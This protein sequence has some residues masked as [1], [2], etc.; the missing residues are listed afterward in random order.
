LEN[1]WETLAAAKQLDDVAFI[2][3]L[4]DL[5]YVQRQYGFTKESFAT[6]GPI[7]PQVRSY[8]AE[9]PG[10][11]VELQSAYLDLV[12]EYAS[13]LALRDGEAAGQELRDQVK[14]QRRKL[15][16]PGSEL[17]RVGDDVLPPRPSRRP[18]PTFTPGAS[19]AGVE[20][21]VVVSVEIWEDGR[22]HNMKVYRH[23]PFGLT[24]SG[25]RALRKWRFEPGTKEGKPVK[26]SATIEM[27]FRRMRR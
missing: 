8:L 15:I 23:F 9:K 21:T 4:S 7:V 11:P 27:N 10:L 16:F 3:A 2:A 25:I 1:A 6:L 13:G 5:A 26:V 17:M 14:E 12:E 24:W 18:E 20:G 19:A 22:A